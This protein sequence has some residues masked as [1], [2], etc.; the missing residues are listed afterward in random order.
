MYVERNEVYIGLNCVFFYRN[1]KSN[2]FIR[3]KVAHSTEKLKYCAH[4]TSIGDS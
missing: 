1:N 3:I 4:L 2:N